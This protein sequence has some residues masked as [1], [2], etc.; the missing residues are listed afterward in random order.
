MT[1]FGVLVSR[2]IQMSYLMETVY[3]NEASH[4]PAAAAGFGTESVSAHKGQG[5]HDAEAQQD[6]HHFEQLIPRGV[7]LM[8]EDL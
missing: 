8:W 7:E 4:K 1:F 2:M 3:L 6:E 5:C